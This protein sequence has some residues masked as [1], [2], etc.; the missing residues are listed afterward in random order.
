MADRVGR[1]GSNGG[2]QWGM[3]YDGQ[4]V[5]AA[6]SDRAGKQTTDANGAPGADSG[7]HGRRRI[8]GSQGFRWKQGLVRSST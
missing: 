3:S 5:Y 4:K 7:S 1:G 2:V 6:V 8:D